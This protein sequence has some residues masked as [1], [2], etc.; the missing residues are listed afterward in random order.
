MSDNRKLEDLK[1]QIA[2]QRAVVFVGTGVS[3]GA[4]MTPLAGWRRF[5]EEGIALCESL[6]GVTLPKTW[7]QRQRTALSENDLD[8]WIGIA[9]QISLKLGG[10]SGGEFRRWLADT[11]GKLEPKKRGTIEALGALGVPLVTTNYDNLI[12]DVTGR[13]TITWRQENKVNKFIQQRRLLDVLHI[14]GHWEESESVILGVRSYDRIIGHEHAQATLRTLLMSGTAVF[15]GYGAGLDDPNFSLLRAWM[16]DVLRGVE[17][18]HYRLCLA[19]EEEQI[20]HAHHHDER[21]VPLVYGSSHED[22][23]AFL[24]SLASTSRSDSSDKSSDVFLAQSA[25]IV[26]SEEPSSHAIQRLAEET[27]ELH[28]LIEDAQRTTESLAVVIAKALA[29]ATKRKDTEAAKFF[30]AE[31]SGYPDVP[32]PDA[33]DYPHHRAMITYCSPNARLNPQYYGWKESA[34][35]VL[36]LLSRDDN[37]VSVKFVTLE[38]MSQI[39]ALAAAP[40]PA[41]SVMIWTKSF[42]T[43]FPNM[44]ENTKWK[45]DHPVACYAPADSYNRIILAVRNEVTRRLLAMEQAVGIAK[46]PTSSD[47]IEEWRKIVGQIIELRPLFG[48]P[49]RP[50][51][52]QKFQVLKVSN[53]DVYFQKES[54]SENITLPLHALTVPWNSSGALRAEIHTGRLWFDDRTERW[55]WDP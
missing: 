6:R 21:I 10:V 20:A 41:A 13:K 51:P 29:L 55:H 39:E 40:R 37:F 54:S 1:D 3:W 16:E 28:S 24:R 52:D 11:V 19:A 47:I 17:H 35:T 9:E 26:S 48:S 4:S 23:E 25:S 12:E 14:H 34:S 46:V 18:R 44:T 49:V 36:D 5:L 53:V 45:P 42:E 7:A 27:R 32:H 38:P 30:R 8:E 50:R 15:I 2:L 22:L 43:V 31:L 33:P